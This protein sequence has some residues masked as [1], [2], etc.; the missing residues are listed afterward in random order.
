MSYDNKVARV[1]INIYKMHA[2]LY[3]SY[4]TK[5]VRAINN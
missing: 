2:Y 5:E 1:L 3:T 4:D